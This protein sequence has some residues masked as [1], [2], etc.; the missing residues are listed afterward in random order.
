V[1]VQGVSNILSAEDKKLLN[2]LQDNFPV[3]VNPYAVIGAELDM[4]EQEVLD[5]VARLKQEGYIRRLGPVFNSAKLGY[6]STLIALAV[7]PEQIDEAA[8][9]I[10]RYMGVTHNYVRAGKYNIWFT[11][12][13]SSKERLEKALNN[14][15]ARTGT[16]EM[17]ILPAS[18]MFKV[19]VNLPMLED[20]E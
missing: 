4:A 5:R 7:P 16:H 14:I 15:R 13:A 3:E 11:F 19:N 2:R 9:V 1:L 17:L 6:T 10:N 18:R 8:E 12:I 20:P